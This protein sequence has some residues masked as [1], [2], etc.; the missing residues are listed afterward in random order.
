MVAKIL[1]LTGSSI[2][3]ILGILHLYYTFFTNKFNARNK[4]VTDEMKNSSP[5][6][7]K[8]TTM[9]NAW[10]GFNASHSAGAVFFGIINI[11]LAAQHFSL[12]QDSVTIISLT[13]T[14]VMFYCW[15]SIKFWFRIPFTGI[16]VAA[17]CFISATILIC[18][19]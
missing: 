9:W 17:G 13:I 1:W 18:F 4:S 12:L 6:L 15:L 19:G 14:T 5:V 10:I 11:L 2:F 3:L 7:T 8:N 16:A